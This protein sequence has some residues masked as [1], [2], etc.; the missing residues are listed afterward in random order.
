MQALVDRP[1]S[2]QVCLLTPSAE[3]VDADSR[4]LLCTSD[5][6]RMRHDMGAAGVSLVR[7]QLGPVYV[8]TSWLLGR[9]RL[10]CPALLHTDIM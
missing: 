8:H 7:E 4:Q 3:A 9:I 6:V 5:Q 1:C 2:A 10:L